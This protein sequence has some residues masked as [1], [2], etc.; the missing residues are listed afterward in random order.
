M[1]RLSVVTMVFTSLFLI[2]SLALGN[3]SLLPRHPGYPMADSKD[4]VLGVPTANDPGEQA[5]SPK[6]ALKQAA[7]F[8]DAHAMNPMKENRP[9]VVHDFNGSAGDSSEDKTSN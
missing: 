8:H 6:E 1:K 7:Q 5:P 3:P 2:C 9:N 4:P